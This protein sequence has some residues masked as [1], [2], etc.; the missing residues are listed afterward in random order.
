MASKVQG[1]LTFNFTLR[2]SSEDAA[3]FNCIARIPVQ[4]VPKPVT[5]SWASRCS[6]ASRLWNALGDDDS[7]RADGQ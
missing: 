4:R 6:M 5:S 2:D 3:P 7:C 1:T